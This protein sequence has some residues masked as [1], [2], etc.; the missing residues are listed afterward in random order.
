MLTLSLEMVA[1]WL[2]GTYS[3]RE[4][5]MEDPVWYIPV[6]LWY[7]PVPRLFSTGLG[8]FT[9]QVNQHTPTNYYRSRVLHLLPDPWRLEN[10]K[11]LDQPA[12]AGAS[13]N[14]E[15]LRRLTSGDC[16]KLEHCTIFLDPRQDH[17]HGSMQ[18]GRRCQLNPGDPAAVEITFDLYPHRFLTLDRGINISTGEQTW[19]S[20]YGPYDYSKKGDP[21][22][23]LDI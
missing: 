2:A 8:F 23:K 17:V 21:P 12:W 3:N 18:P 16:T 22:V 9:E 13:Q 15:H 14:A 10:Y 11:L 4:Q 6:T 1:T 7:V 19:G 5:A 20:R